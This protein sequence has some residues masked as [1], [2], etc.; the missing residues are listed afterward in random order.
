MNW[1]SSHT[2]NA[3]KLIGNQRMQEKYFKLSQKYTP[4]RAHV[5]AMVIH[6]CVRIRWN[7]TWLECVFPHWVESA[8]NRPI[9]DF[10]FCITSLQPVEIIIKLLQVLLDWTVNSNLN[11][12]KNGNS[13]EIAS[14]LIPVVIT[15]MLSKYLDFNRLR[16]NNPELFTK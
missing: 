12:T 13:L 5:I 9:V 3:Q 7:S 1:I 10:L 6:T 15:L 8:W 14:Q 4:N 2:S 16:S 11:R